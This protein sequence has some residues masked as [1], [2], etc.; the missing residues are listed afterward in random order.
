MECSSLQMLSID[1]SM[2]IEI[3][4][5]EQNQALLCRFLL[6]SFFF[7]FLPVFQLVDAYLFNC[8]QCLLIIKTQ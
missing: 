1:I 3:G 5:R 4:V 8:I 7:S 2:C 6:V